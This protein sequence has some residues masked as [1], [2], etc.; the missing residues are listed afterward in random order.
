M[1]ALPE[2]RGSQSQFEI[3]WTRRL[4][5]K[6]RDWLNGYLDDGDRE[7]GSRRRAK[8]LTSLDMPME[9]TRNRLE[10]LDDEL[11]GEPDSL[12][13]LQQSDDP[14]AQGVEHTTGL[15]AL[16]SA[17][18]EDTLWITFD[19][20][21]RMPADVL[22]QQ[23]YH[24]QRQASQPIEPTQP[25]GLQKRMPTQ[26]V[27]AQEVSRPHTIQR[28]EPIQYDSP[29]ATVK[30]ELREES[31]RTRVD[32]HKNFASEPESQVRPV[33]PPV[34]TTTHRKLNSA[35]PA[36]VAHPATDETLRHELPRP[37]I[38]AV[39]K[40]EP[41]TAFDFLHNFEVDSGKERTKLTVPSKSPV[42]SRAVPE[43]SPSLPDENA[44]Q[45]G[46]IGDVAPSHSVHLRKSSSPAQ[47]SSRFSNVPISLLRSPLQRPPVASQPQAAESIFTAIRLPEPQTQP[48]QDFAPATSFSPQWA[49]NI[50]DLWPDLPTD[51]GPSQFELQI[52]MRQWERASR[53]SRE[54]Q[55]V[56]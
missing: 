12:T 26:E 50:E 3:R 24:V 41:V 16:S 43:I 13:A 6:L 10:F 18:E 30:P 22:P 7:S 51:P 35:P 4:A 33:L 44:R 56:L 48:Q 23:H 37:S 49:E 29:K 5:G 42:T 40:E 38:D 46:Y 39:S 15:S 32:A 9:D 55:G 34:S 52:S 11:S 31:S 53:L 21:Q 14:P 36:S 2:R 19:D 45:R 17:E 8:K 25:D 28:L 27:R 54:Q 20:R 1:R 47:V